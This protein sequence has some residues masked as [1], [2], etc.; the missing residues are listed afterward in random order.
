MMRRFIAL[1]LSGGL[2]L[3]AMGLAQA[4]APKTVWE[5]PAGDAD[6]AQGLGQSIPGGFDLVTGAIAKNGANLEFTVTHADMPPSGSLPEGF[7]FLW[8]FAVGDEMYRLSVKTADIGKPD[9]LG[10][11]TTERVG[12]VDASGQFRLENE[13]AA[14]ETIGVLQPINCAPLAYLE[15]VWD[16]A[17]KS[18]TFP[19]PLKLLGAKTGTVIGPG[20]GDAAAICQ[21]CWVSHA[22]ERSHSDTLIDTA[23][24]ATTYKVP[25]K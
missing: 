10:G 3:G 20:G 18:F 22:A 1:L 23:A 11:Q 5:D 25:K 14:G 16:P 21:I 19:V 6:N 12:R 24:M 13:C 2:V 15:G 17:S 9:V 7:R 4:G 8:A